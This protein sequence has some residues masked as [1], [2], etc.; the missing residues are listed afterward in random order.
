MVNSFDHSDIITWTPQQNDCRTTDCNTMPM[1][2]CKYQMHLND[3]SLKE[4][5]RLQ[6][7]RWLMLTH[8]IFSES[9][10]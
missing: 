5:E 3:M 1:P 6:T 8:L 10:F 2:L 9:T 4:P 7:V